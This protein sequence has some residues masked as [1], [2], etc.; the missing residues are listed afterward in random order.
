MKSFWKFF[1]L[2]LFADLRN[3]RSIF[4]VILFPM[5]LF[6]ILVL[7]FTNMGLRESI[8]FKALLIDETPG[9]TTVNYSSKVIKALEKLSYPNEGALF[10]IEKLDSKDKEKALQLLRYAQAD[11]LIVIPEDF[12]TKFAGLALSSSLGLPFSQ[13]NL[14]IYFVPSRA[15]S[16]LARGTIEAVMS[17]V[18]SQL[19][20]DFNYD[21]D[22]IEV[23][24]ETIGA[25]MNSPS[26]TN[27]V[28]PGIIVI[29]V[30]MSGT[31]LV[32]PKIATMRRF[33][34]LKKY[35][36][37]PV[38]LTSFYFGFTFSRIFI[39][40][41]QYVGLGLF[42]IF[43]LNATISLFSINA[44]IYYLYLCAVYTAIGFAL[45]FIS[46]SPAA[47]GAIS[48]FLTLPLQFLS[49]IYFPLF[50]LPWYINVFVYSNPL[51]YSANAMREYMGV[52]YS[53]SPMWLN[54]LVPGIWLLIS[55][56]FSLTRRMSERG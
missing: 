28:A 10:T 32:G 40:F 17:N 48:G 12:N 34:I 27:F 16:N 4:W 49:G 43:I 11:I 44:V 18:N 46:T 1:K 50:N 6:S 29:A 21:V 7:T 47:Q 31:F 54:Y 35:A 24:S 51:Y 33:N 2:H 14:K 15:S 41:V 55:V 26:Y 13:A 56:V 39:M 23:N 20:K 37:T 53:T 19:A 22:R 45:G 52:A 9:N 8:D 36:T 5:L 25:I 3:R 30:F 42:G 38:P